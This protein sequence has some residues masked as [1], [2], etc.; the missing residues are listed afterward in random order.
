MSAESRSRAEELL[1]ESKQLL[2][3][4]TTADRDDA[5]V[6]QQRKLNLGRQIHQA[7]AARQVN[8]TYA[9][10]AAYGRR[11]STMDVQK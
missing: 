7:S 4:I 8:R 6:L 11:E 1:D 9:A 2:E 3:Q 5:L 10:A